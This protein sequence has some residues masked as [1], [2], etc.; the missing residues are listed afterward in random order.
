MVIYQIYMSRKMS[1]PNLNNF[2][3]FLR[4]DFLAGPGIGLLWWHFG[5]LAGVVAHSNHLLWHGSKFL[6]KIR[7]DLPTRRK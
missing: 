5:S 6:D 3:L 1:Q 4:F 2:F 7:Q